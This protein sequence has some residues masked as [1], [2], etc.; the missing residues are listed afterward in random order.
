M[1]RPEKQLTPDASPRDWFGHELRTWRKKRSPLTHAELGVK[2]QVSGSLIEKIEK[3]TAT[4]SKDLAERLDEVLQTGGVL[5][6]AWG[7]VFG[8]TE[9]ARPETESAPPAGRRCRF[10]SMK[11]ASWAEVAQHLRAGALPLWTVAPSSLRAALPPSP[12]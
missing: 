2:V 10:R 6:R 8:Q 12:P 5:T 9:K 11:A 3:G 7:M 4:C 1:P